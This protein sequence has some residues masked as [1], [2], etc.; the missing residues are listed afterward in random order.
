MLLVAGADARCL[1]IT[2]RVTKVD[3][4]PRLLASVHKEQIV[5]TDHIPLSATNRQATVS[6]PEPILITIGLLLPGITAVDAVLQTTHAQASRELAR[7]KCYD[8][9]SIVHDPVVTSTTYKFK[10][11]LQTTSCPIERRRNA[12]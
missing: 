5:T 11:G 10:P 1:A 7:S 12:I 8:H 6:H 3:Q 2:D 4:G 9:R